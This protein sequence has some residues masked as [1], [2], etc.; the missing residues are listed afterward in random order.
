MA[1]ALQQQAAAMTGVMLYHACRYS[2]G[3][4]LQQACSLFSLVRVLFIII[5]K[6]PN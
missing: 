5:I 6:L 3:V 2:H 4:S 1:V